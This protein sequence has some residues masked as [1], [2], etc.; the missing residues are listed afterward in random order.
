[1]L[2]LSGFVE[3]VLNRHGTRLVVIAA[4]IPPG[5]TVVI[6]V[7]RT[8]IEFGTW[9]ELVLNRA[10]NGCL[11]AV[12]TACPLATREVTVK[13]AL[14]DA[15]SPVV[16]SRATVLILKVPSFMLGVQVKVLVRL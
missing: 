6:G 12:I 13:E 2:V 10:T 14:A 8:R 5:G 9:Q 15:V 16:V 4:V 1:M 7:K 11:V 3:V